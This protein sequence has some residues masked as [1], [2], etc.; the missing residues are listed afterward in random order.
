MKRFPTLPKDSDVHL[1]TYNQK[2]LLSG[3][4]KL[5]QYVIPDNLDYLSSDEEEE[6]DQ[7]VVQTK[8]KIKCNSDI[9]AFP[10]AFL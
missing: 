8:V 3:E 7:Q 9:G 6:V 1:S 2:S 10:S 4:K 5:P